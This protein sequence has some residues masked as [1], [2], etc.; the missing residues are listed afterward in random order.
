MDYFSLSCIIEAC[1][2]TFAFGKA[3]IPENEEITCE[4]LRYR[5]MIVQKLRG[6]QDEE[7]NWQTGSIGA[8]GSSSG[9]LQ[10]EAAE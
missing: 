6:L 2:E 1:S 8:D 7:K 3:G 5:V 9:W 4:E 10:R